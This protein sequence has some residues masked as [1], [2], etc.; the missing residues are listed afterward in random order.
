MKNYP[1]VLTNMN[2]LT[3]CKSM[4]ESLFSLNGSSDITIIDN[5]STYPP[6]L[7]W[8][9]E[10]KNDVKV[11]RHAGNHGPWVFFNSNFWST[12]DSEFYIYSDA[13]L[14]LNSAMPYNWQEIMKDYYDKYQGDRKISLAL[15][16]EDIPDHYEY[17]DQVK[18]HQSV[19]WY[20]TEEEN[21]YKAI[22]DMSFTMDSKLKGYRYESVR[23]AGKFMAKHIPWYIDFNNI[24]EEEKYYIEH[25]NPGFNEAMYS[26]THYNRLKNKS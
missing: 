12:I 23:L 7:D 8:Y 25:I 24:S 10:I 6:L 18:N 16:L 19:C 26:F 22:T 3:T 13:D 11:I 5:A 1:I 14:E 4:V 2:R 15:D 17:I 20:P 9:E 21:V